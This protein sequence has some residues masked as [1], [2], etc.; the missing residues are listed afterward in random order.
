MRHSVKNRFLVE[1]RH[2]LVGIFL[3][4]ILLPGLVL[5]FVAMRTLR[6]EERLAQQQIQGILERTA[7]Q[8]GRSLDRHF[9]QWHEERK[10]K[11]ITSLRLR[12][13]SLRRSFVLCS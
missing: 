11:F 12:V 4:F 1:P 8:L 5:G 7:E 3:V 2:R 10:I 9:S 13:F 6:Q